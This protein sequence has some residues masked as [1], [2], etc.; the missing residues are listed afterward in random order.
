MNGHEDAEPPEVRCGDRWS[1]AALGLLAAYVVLEAL[2]LSFGTVSE[3]GAGF[4]PLLLATAL[5]GLAA[6][7]TITARARGPGIRFAR[8]ARDVAAL[9][10]SLLVVAIFIDRLGFVLCAAAAMLLLLR[11][12]ARLSWPRSTAFAVAGALVVFALFT[13]LG[14]P[15]PKGLLLPL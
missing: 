15:L 4:F 11:T 12:V 9:I 8:E 7:I 2:R 5:F 13:G 14:V 3:P 1:G 10:G 6:A